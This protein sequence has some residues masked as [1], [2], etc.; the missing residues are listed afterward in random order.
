MNNR[1]IFLLITFT[2]FAC[3]YTD[4]KEPILNDINTAKDLIKRSIA[5]HDPNGNWRHFKS[6]I[7]INSSVFWENG[8]VAAK[9]DS[10]LFF[11]NHK[12]V[13]K[14]YSLRNS[15]EFINGIKYR[16]EIKH[17]GEIS[18]DTCYNIVLNEMLPEVSSKYKW[19]YGCNGITF[20]RDYYSYLIGM[21]MKLLDSEAVINDTIFER[22]YNDI[23]YDVIKVNYNPIDKEPVWYFYFNKKNHAFE[24]CKFTS[25]EDENKGGEYIIYKQ[26]K[27]IQDMRLK[28]QQI[29]LYNTP[30]LDTLGIDNLQ[31][32]KITNASNLYNSLLC[33]DLLGISSPSY[34]FAKLVAITRN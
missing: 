5:Y 23:K 33:S 9:T 8:G 28:S 16:N 3:R 29:W 20:F 34:T 25:I 15:T 13:F 21:P 32:Q 14:I 1:Y 12:G 27:N 24:L 22:T 2:I 17:K 26:E 18:K 4:K 6:N 11:D 19:L 30:E 31:Y 10:K 7:E